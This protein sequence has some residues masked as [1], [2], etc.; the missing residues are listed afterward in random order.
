VLASVR[1][2]TLAPALAAAPRP[3]QAAPTAKADAGALPFTVAQFNAEN[4]F[5]A[6]DNSGGTNPTPEGYATKL[7]KLELAITGEL[8]SPDVIAL[9]EIGNPQALA[10]LLSKTSLGAAGYKALDLPSN[11][12]RH[13]GVALLYQSNKVALDGV[14]QLTPNADPKANLPKAGG[15]VDPDKLFAR[16]PLVANFTVTG[17]G[18]AADGAHQVQLV[19]NHWLA[20][21]G[22]P[23]SAPRRDAEA[24]FLAGYVDA[25]RAATPTRGVIVLGDL[26][27]GYGDSSYELL[28]GAGDKTRMYDAPKLGVADADRYTYMYH[29]QPDMLDHMLMTPDL[30]PAVQSVQISHF[31]TRD[32]SDDLHAPAHRDDPTTAAGV[33]DHDPILTTFDL[34]KQL[35][36]APAAH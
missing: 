22:G 13:I 14:S 20:R 12:K 31:N 28:A 18:Q 15:Q 10:D 16:P 25:Q 8:H 4:F 26:N 34:S 11:D 27:S 29:G 5:P 36:G 2:L 7:K 17:A 24:S 32:W 6:G 23:S 1:P 19:V 35:V 33:S 9:E 30:K 3:A 21:L